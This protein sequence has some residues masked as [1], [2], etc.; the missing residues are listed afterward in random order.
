MISIIYNS[1]DR[2]Y[3]KDNY[4]IN[5]AAQDIANSTSKKDQNK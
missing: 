4:D 3:D 1:A 5:K 2:N